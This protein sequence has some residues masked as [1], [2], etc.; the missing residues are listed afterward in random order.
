MY[1][2]LSRYDMSKP[3]EEPKPEE[4]KEEPKPEPAKPAEDPANTVPAWAVEELQK[5]MDYGITDGSRPG[6][7]ATR[8]DVAVMVKRGVEYALKRM[9]VE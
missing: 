5:A 9:G 6:A 7:S 1:A 4:P 8:C 2:P 3:K